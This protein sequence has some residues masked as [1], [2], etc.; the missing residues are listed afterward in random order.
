MFLPA[1]LGN[2]SEYPEIFLPEPQIWRRIYWKLLKDL[3]QSATTTNRIFSIM[4]EQ[5]QQLK[6]VRVG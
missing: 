6:D 3:D 1:N 4:T 5:V 2:F